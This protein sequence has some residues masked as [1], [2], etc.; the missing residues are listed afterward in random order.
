MR[1]AV[2]KVNYFDWVA[3]CNDFETSSHFS[4]HMH[5]R[6]KTHTPSKRARKKT[7]R[8]GSLPKGS[9]PKEWE[10]DTHMQ[11]GS[12]R[13]RGKRERERERGKGRKVLT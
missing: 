3:T 13:T 6:S 4:E 10:S 12:G 9:L 2:H 11:R 7:A 1:R 8:R 5:T